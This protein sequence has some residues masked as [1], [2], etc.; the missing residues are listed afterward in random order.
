MASWP[1]GNSEKG[2]N[3]EAQ[4]SRPPR[5]QIHTCS[6]THTVE[7]SGLIFTGSEIAWGGSRNEAW[8]QNWAT[9]QQE[10]V[11]S[12]LAALKIIN[13]HLYYLFEPARTH[14]STVKVE[15]HKNV[16]SFHSTPLHENTEET[17]WV[18]FRN[19]M[20]VKTCTLTYGEKWIIESK[21][22][23]RK[24]TSSTDRLFYTENVYPAYKVH[25]AK[26]TKNINKQII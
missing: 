6:F 26:T 21:T 23:S 12:H 13:H 22:R 15:G 2:E 1:Y 5:R 8:S 20:D 11:K 7:V 17:P 19:I 4:W 14:T 10:N 25:T 18:G 3:S 24:L 9:P 16:P